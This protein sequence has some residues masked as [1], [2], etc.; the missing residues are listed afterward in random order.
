MKNIY[1][2][3]YK[4]YVLI[5]D[6]IAI[7]LTLQTH[8]YGNA[9]QYLTSHGVSYILLLVKYSLFVV[10]IDYARQH[11]TCLRITCHCSRSH[12]HAFF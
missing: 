1:S 3:N 2:G 6:M 11:T 5:M 12:K 9:C 7:N 8:V 10:R 4:I